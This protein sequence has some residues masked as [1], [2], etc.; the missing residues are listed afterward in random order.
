MRKKTLS[1][2]TLGIILMTGSTALAV[3]FSQPMTEDWYNSNP[4][5]NIP[6][7]NMPLSNTMNLYQAP[8]YLSSA[9]SSVL[10]NSDLDKYNYPKDNAWEVK[11]GTTLSLYILGVSA[12]NTNTIGYYYTDA[13][14]TIQKTPLLPNIT[15]D[16]WYGNGTVATPL[17]GVDFTVNPSVHII[18]WYIDSEYAVDNYKETFYSEP[19][20]NPDRHDHLITYALPE[21]KGVFNVNNYFTNDPS[22]HTFTGSAY[23]VGFEDSIMGSGS[24]QGV[25]TL[26]DDDFNDVMFLIDSNYIQPATV[27]EPATI[28]LFAAGFAGLFF[29]GRRKRS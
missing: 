8:A 13:A 14:G 21:L 9:Y 10:R 11:S 4:P 1:I 6:T 29:L 22:T 7:P 28:T 27:P 17:R 24:Y 2:L 3:P 20:I 26:G 19:S 23:L 18:G 25:P 15:G 12:G 16:K 5:N